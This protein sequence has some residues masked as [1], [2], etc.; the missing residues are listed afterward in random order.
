MT[1]E[2]REV[3][4]E[5]M[6]LALYLDGHLSVDE[7]DLINHALDSLGWES[8]RTREGFVHQAFLDAREGASCELKT[9]E[10]L[11]ARLSVIERDGQQAAALT[12]LSKVLGSDGF[13]PAEAHFLRQ[14]E[15]RL[16]PSV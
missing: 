4:I 3:L 8:D 11:D 2:S 13:T 1:Q 9:L 7:D 16:Y 14:I 12:W 5:L 6:F 15:A 10:F